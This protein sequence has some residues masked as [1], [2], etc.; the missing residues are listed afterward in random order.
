[1]RIALL[2]DIHG[3]RLALDAV[4]ADIERRGGVDSYWIL[5]DLCAIGTDPAGV[6][7]RLDAL[8]NLIAVAGNADRYVTTGDRPAPSFAQVR[9]NPDLI[10]TLAEV[11]G[12]FGWTQGFLEARGWLEWLAALP[13]EQRLTVPDGAGVLL[14]HVAPGAADGKG[15][16]PGLDDVE[17]QAALNGEAADLICVGHFHMPM[18]RRLN[19]QHI[20]NPGAVSNGFGPDLR[21]AYAILSADAQG[22]AIQHY[23]V[24]YDRAAAIDEARR[25]SN[26]GAAYIVRLLEGQ[27]RATWMQR[28]DGRA[29]YPTFAD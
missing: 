25:C 4:L 29:Y 6:L 15:L 17:L 7:E 21:A 23:R 1:M 9:D 2:A 10:P 22:H 13:Y 11:A 20:V 18:S 24:D 14:T 16:N 19:G 8:P 12:S 5:G 26:P 28:W 27:V 3:N